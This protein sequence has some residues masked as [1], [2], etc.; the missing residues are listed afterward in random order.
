MRRAK[1]SWRMPRKCPHSVRVSRA[2][3]RVPAH[4]MRHLRRWL[5]PPLPALM[6]VPHFLRMP[7]LKQTPAAAMV[8][9]AL[10][11]ASRSRGTAPRA[12]S[13]YAAAG[14]TARVDKSVDI[15]ALDAQGHTALMLAIRR[16]DSA[17]VDTLLAQGADAAMK[18]AD[19]TTPLQ[20]ATLRGQP[21]IIRSLQKALRTKR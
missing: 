6:L 7:L 18:D 14:N 19:G 12:V 3:P 4:G 20:A 17:A 8:A 16:D 13:E 21:A 9:D 5:P 1:I 15:N 11:A 2:A 10:D